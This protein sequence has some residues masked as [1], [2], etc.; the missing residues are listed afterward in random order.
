MMGMIANKVVVVTGSG[1]GLGRALVEAFLEQGCIVVGIGRHETEIAQAAAG[2]RQIKA[3]VADARQVRAAFDEI[4]T[5]YG[6]VDVLFNNAAVYPRVSFLD[7]SAEAFADALAINL[8]GVANCCKAVL[9]LMIQQGWGRIYNVG[10]WAD[11]APIGRSAVY[12][13]SKGGLH[14]LT[15]AIAADTLDIVADLQIHEWI[16]GHMKTQMSDFTGM[17]PRTCADWAVCIVR[18]DDASARSC[19]FEGDREWRPLESLRAR[20]KKRV[21][22]WRSTAG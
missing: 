21:L 17:E 12:S 19:I 22:F 11:V 5:V 6:R 2:Y 3:D 16:P 7:E 13:A 10:S 14:A 15:K 8:G 20:I 18:R 4:R 9:P 1:A